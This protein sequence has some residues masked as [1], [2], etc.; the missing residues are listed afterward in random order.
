[1][2]T[3]RFW[4]PW[5]SLGLLIGLAL[6]AQAA[7]RVQIPAGEVLPLIRMKAGEEAQALP[8]ASF[9]LDRNP[10]TNAAFLSFVQAHPQWR[11]GSA[12][13]LLTEASHLA[14]WAA[15]LELGPAAPPESPV[16]EVSWFA[17]RAYCQAQGGRLPTEAEWELAAAAGFLGA[18]GRAEPDF[19]SR[20]LEWYARKAPTPL[21]AVAG[22]R[23]NFFGVYDLHGLVWEWVEDFAATLVTNDIREAGDAPSTTFCG[24]GALSAT[25]PADYAAFMRSAFRGALKGR[26]TLKNLGFRC[27]ADAQEKRP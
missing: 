15:A 13:A 11:K 27:A 9:W 19:R 3:P 23:P 20:I 18:N 22:G 1:M 16:V 12:P 7:P 26:H 14:R 24:G 21:P 4:S 17:A 5:W 10:V 25:D 2:R 8:V 6:G